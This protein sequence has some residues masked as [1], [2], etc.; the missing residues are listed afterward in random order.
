[1][2]NLTADYANFEVSR[3]LIDCAIYI[4]ASFVL[5]YPLKTIDSLLLPHISSYASKVNLIYMFLVS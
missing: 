2:K 5:L 1:M 3:W 4:H